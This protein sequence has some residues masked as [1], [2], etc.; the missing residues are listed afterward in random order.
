MS[1]SREFFR[2]LFDKPVIRHLASFAAAVVVSVGL[3]K[4]GIDPTTA[5][6]AGKVVGEAIKTIPTE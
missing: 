6:Q 3:T 2:R 4:A 1:K 5:K